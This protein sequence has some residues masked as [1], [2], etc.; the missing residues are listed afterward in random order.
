MS[1]I[2]PQTR[3]EMKFVFIVNGRK[4][5]KFLLKELKKAIESLGREVDYEIF[6]TRAPRDATEYVKSY[7]VDGPVCFVACGGDGTINEVASAVAC[8]EN[9]YL[10]VYAAGTGNDFIKYYKNI[11]FRDLNAI[12]NGK[13]EKIDILKVGERFSI[14]VCNFGFDSAVA[15]LGAKLSAKGVPYAY[16][17]S[18]IPALFGGLS[19]RISVRADGE[20]ICGDRMLL[21]TLGNNSYNGGEFCCA[22]R[23]VNNDGL[24]E[25]CLVKPI[26]LFR[27][28]SMIS[29]YKR[30]EHLDD[31]RVSDCIIY[32]RVKR[33]DISS[34]KEIE[35]CIDG[36]MISGR[37]F[38][39]EILPSAVNF[40]LPER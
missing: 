36:E 37:D 7:K 29:V 12:I 31:P 6:T 21:C 9:K 22:P 40:I 3:L 19:K 18:I 11:S 20:L 16:R 34:P 30:G 1:L 38:V 25:L 33:V 24:I 26:S 14:N 32:R 8:E 4:D 17:L 28:A 2:H 10:S 35:L 39:V 23:A 5:K 15:S 13:H 27:F